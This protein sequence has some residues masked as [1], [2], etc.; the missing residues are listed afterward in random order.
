M[1][2]FIFCTHPQISL[3]R[4]NQAECGGQGMWHAWERRE[5]C[6]VFRRES[7]IRIVQKVNRS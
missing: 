6:T 3:G 7:Y 1:N 4:S 2:R 5:N